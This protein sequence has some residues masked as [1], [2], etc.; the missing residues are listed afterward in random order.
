MCDVH[1][2]QTVFL[3]C[4]WVFVPKKRSISLVFCLIFFIQLTHRQF[5]AYISGPFGIICFFTCGKKEWWW[6]GIMIFTVQIC[7]KIWQLFFSNFDFADRMVSQTCASGTQSSNEQHTWSFSTH[8]TNATHLVASHTLHMILMSFDF[9][10]RWAMMNDHQ[11]SGFFLF[12][13]Y[14]CSTAIFFSSL[15]HWIRCLT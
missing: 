15:K 2:I 6:K 14:T 9:I 7:Q 5:W 8:F 11:A 13:F 3:V 12:N 10:Q 4:P 1:E